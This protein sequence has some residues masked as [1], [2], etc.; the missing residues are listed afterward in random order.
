MRITET[1]LVTSFLTISSILAFDQSDGKNSENKNLNSTSNSTDSSTIPSTFIQIVP[2][3]G[4][5]DSKNETMK[6]QAQSPYGQ[7]IGPFGAN[8]PLPPQL[9]AAMQRRQ[10]M[11]NQQSK[12]RSFRHSCGDVLMFK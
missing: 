2:L 4:S 6:A 11:L 1:I 12:N 3:P 8:S 7:G 10:Q 9:I 5:S